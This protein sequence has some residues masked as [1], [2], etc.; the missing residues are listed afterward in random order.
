[1]IYRESITIQHWS[2][3][4][5]GCEQAIVLAKEGI[6]FTYIYVLLYTRLQWVKYIRLSILRGQEQKWA[7]CGACL[8]RNQDYIS[9]P[10]V[11]YS[12]IRYLYLMYALTLEFTSRST[13]P[14]LLVH[15]WF[16][17]VYLLNKWFLISDFNGRST[18]SRGQVPV[19]WNV[20]G[21]WHSPAKL[22]TNSQIFVEIYVWNV[23]FVLNPFHH[24]L[25][26][27]S[28]VLYNKCLRPSS[29]FQCHV[30][31]VNKLS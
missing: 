4:W 22:F 20:N 11:Y 16:I 12:Y 17:Y 21:T 10:V 8:V 9:E 26:N 28:Q 19:E 30:H 5:L 24:M 25:G 6:H 13:V 23:P 3:Q 2:S 14:S 15:A 7:S 27:V 1:M 31:K 29:P 18:Y